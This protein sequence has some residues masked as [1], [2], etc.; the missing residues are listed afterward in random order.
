MKRRRENGK[1]TH[2]LAS[3]RPL[4]ATEGWKRRRLLRSSRQTPLRNTCR[5]HW[6]A[7]RTL[8]R[9]ARE[10]SVRVQ[11]KAEGEQR[12]G[13]VGRTPI[14]PEG[15]SSRQTGRSLTIFSMYSR[16]EARRRPMTSFS[17]DSQ[18]MTK[19]RGDWFDT[20]HCKGR[21]RSEVVS[22]KQSRGLGTRDRGPGSSGTDGGSRREGFGPGKE[23][24]VRSVRRL[25]VKGSIG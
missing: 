25:K 22:D 3:G 9:A 13:Q 18:S 7:C 19:A 16:S 23:R 5:A 1:K 8:T 15:R 21:N 2:V 17:G 4:E 12:K 20:L 11:I 14:G 6:R 24:S 10:G